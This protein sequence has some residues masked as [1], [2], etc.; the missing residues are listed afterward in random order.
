MNRSG[1]SL[2]AQALERLGVSFGAPLIGADKANVRGYYEHEDITRN[3]TLLMHTCYDRRGWSDIGELR[4]LEDQDVKASQAHIDTIED[5]VEREVDRC[6]LFGLK[7]PF[8]PR[9]PHLWGAV[10]IECDVDPIYIHAMRWPKDVYRSVL[11]SSGTEDKDTP[12]AYRKFL[13]LWAWSNAMLFDY[14]PA[15]EIWMD[16]WWEDTDATMKKLADAIGRETVPTEG[17]LL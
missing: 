17:L 6:E 16:S 7:L 13:R 10:F 11:K 4:E 12:E 2:I 15:C 14:E 3:Q 5:I 9:I 8:L 1:T